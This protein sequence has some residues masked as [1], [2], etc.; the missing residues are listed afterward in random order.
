MPMLPADQVVTNFTE[1][2]TGLSEDG[3]VAEGQRCFQCGFR[4]QITPAPRPPVRVRK[5]DVPV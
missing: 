5:T 2:E 4:S 3:T 1:V